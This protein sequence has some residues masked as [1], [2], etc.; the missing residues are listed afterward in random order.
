MQHV[1]TPGCYQCAV[2]GMPNAGGRVS[3]LSQCD[4]CQRFFCSTHADPSDHVFLMGKK[5]TCAAHNARLMRVFE[6]R[7][8][9][10]PA[11]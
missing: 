10:V 8:V 9:A 2:M 3:T 7:S 5:E 4:C 1:N 6:S 11:R